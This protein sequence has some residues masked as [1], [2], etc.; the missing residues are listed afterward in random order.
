MF[1]F[2]ALS[3]CVL[4]SSVSVG[5]EVQSATFFEKKDVAELSTINIRGKE[6]NTPKISTKK[7]LKV[8]GAGG[9]PLRAIEALPGVVLGGYG[10]YS[11]PAVR[12]ASPEDNIYI[13]DFVPVGYVFHNDGGSTYND[14]LVED[15]KLMAGAWGSEYYNALGSVMSTHLRDP[16]PEKLTTTLDLGL[17]RVGGLVE[18]AISDDSAF[19]V[20]YRRSMLEFYVE[21]FIDEDELTFTEVPKN[22]DYQ[23]KYHWRVS[24]RS[25]LRLI[26]SGAEDSVE[27]KLGEESDFL[28]HEPDLA[29]GVGIEGSYDNQA[30]LFD[31]IL[32]GGTSA[33]FAIS[34]KE[35]NTDL[36]FGSLYDLDAKDLEKRVKNYYQ[37]PLSNGDSLT[38]GIDISN[39]NVE[40]FSS[41]KFSPCNEE[42][43]NCPPFSLGEA[44]ISN[45]KLEINAGYAFAKYNWMA[46]PY[47][48][49]AIGFGLANND[50]LKDQTQHPRIDARLELNERWI[51][52]AA[53]GKHHQFPRPREFRFIAEDFGNPDLKMPNSDHYV[54]GF[55]YTHGDSVSAKVEVYYKDIH[56][57]MVSN[58][59]YLTDPVN[60]KTYLN[61]AK[62]E[63]YGLELLINK[64]L[65]E[66]W[67]GWLSLAYSK[68]KRTDTLRD[69]NFNYS[70]DRPWI[71]N[72][73]A[74]YKKSN[75]TTYG[76]KWRYQSGN[77]F[78]PVNSAEAVDSDGVAV[79]LNGSGDP[80]DADSVYLWV[81][82][83]AG[84][85]SERLPASHRLDFRIDYEPKAD[86]SYYLEIINVYNQ[87]NV[88]EYKYSEDFSEREKVESLPTIISVGMK[89]VY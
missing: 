56:D 7:L 70:Y 8:P 82:T 39:N 50:Y 81:P 30:I 13:T 31:T 9:D 11:V 89:L 45:E 43:E 16:Y 34:H 3:L 57:L 61:A 83:Y 32:P 10:S 48:D 23:F 44:F 74:S 24:G 12:G 4:G 59:D 77:L 65:T 22:S 84:K 42:F 76:W 87:L 78:T 46:T 54:A 28:Q 35:E 21:N 18:G 60:E 88:T 79:P 86:A 5:E 15:F 58:P 14:N 38:Y 1:R 67:Y 55:E 40:Y 25:N 72:L 27:I 36:G 66:K 29:G 62:G 85:N 49:I 26:A 71:M 47:L 68:T 51:L 20:S 63:A 69:I 33:I 73:V 53:A 37:T 75:T 80:L 52:T 6:A 19:Y 2:T 64:N 41:G 17:L